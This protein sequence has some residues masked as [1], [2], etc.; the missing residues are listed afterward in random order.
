MWRYWISAKVKI[1][2]KVNAYSITAFYFICLDSLFN[3]YI[4]PYCFCIDFDLFPLSLVVGSKSNFLFN[5]LT[6]FHP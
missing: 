4:V 2:Q 6:S 1:L 5:I 3:T